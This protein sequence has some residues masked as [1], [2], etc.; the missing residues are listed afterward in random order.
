MIRPLLTLL[1]CSLLG[2]QPRA[3]PRPAVTEDK[4]ADPEPVVQGGLLGTLASGLDSVS[5]ELDIDHHLLDDWRL[6]T[7]RAANEA[8][9]L[10]ARHD[11]GDLLAM[12]GDFLILTATWAA[13]FAVLFYLGRLAT[14]ASQ[15]SRLLR[16]RP[17]PQKLLGYLLPYTLPAIASL[18]AALFV[19]RQ[20]DPSV[21]RALGMSLA[22]ATSSGIFSTTIIPVSY[23]HLRAHET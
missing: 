17:R 6:R 15:H 3:A 13:S 10:V 19:S 12:T 23:T 21:G 18:P 1:L 8:N 22:Y 7:D 20:L 9:Q 4:P 11:A 16:N 2:W 14:R 5:E